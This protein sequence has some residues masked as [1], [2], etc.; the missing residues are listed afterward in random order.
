MSETRGSPSC[1]SRR[2]DDGVIFV[3][4]LL[5]PRRRLDVPGDERRSQRAGD[6]LREQRLAGAGL[7]LDQQR[8]LERD[9]G[10]DRG[11]EFVAGHIG[12]RALKSHRL[13]LRAASVSKI[14]QN[15]AALVNSSRP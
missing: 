12:G 14:C 6:L 8:A 7:A 9:R 1:E 13:Q 5:G 4:A 2:R 10:V 3:E 11:F 15:A